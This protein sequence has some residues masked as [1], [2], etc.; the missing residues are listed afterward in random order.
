MN[1]LC[2]DV[3]TYSVKAVLFNAE[4]KSL[5]VKKVHEISLRDVGE[6]LYPDGNLYEKQLAIVADLIGER[7]NGKVYF[8]LPNELITSRHLTLPVT[9]R[10]KVDLMI[11]FQLDENLPYSLDQAHFVAQQT[12]RGN[13]TNVLVNVTKKSDFNNYH[14]TL[15]ICEL[16]PTAVTSELSVVHS[17]AAEK[18]I[19]GPMAII[20][21]GHSTTKCYIIYNE[22]VVLNHINY[23]AGSLIDEAIASTYNIDA[24]EAVIYKHQNCFFLTQG[25]LEGVNEKQREFA[26]LMTKTIS[27][28]M[29]D[30]RR[31][32]IGF[33]VKNGLNINGVYLT[34]GTSRI[35]NIHDFMSEQLGLQVEPLATMEGIKDRE[36]LITNKEDS[37]FMT[38]LMAQATR[39]KL[40]PSNFLTG[41][42]SNGSSMGLPLH[43]MAFI[44]IRSAAL[45]LLL[46]LFVGIDSYFVAKQEKGLNK[47]IVTQ[48]KDPALGLDRKLR[49]TWTRKIP[50]LIKS[51]KTNKRVVTQEVKSM[52]SAMNIN[53]VT[54]L[55]RVNQ[56]LMGTQ[57]VELVVF[58]SD[59]TAIS[60]TLKSKNQT[61]HDSVRKK[62]NSSGLSD[63]KLSGSGLTTA[64][65]F[66]HS[67]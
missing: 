39:A 59:G 15:K 25:Q 53:A 36:D 10:K 2:I 52:M 56:V 34:G 49:K 16:E 67:E 62:L 42:Y 13:E 65:R 18:K 24:D 64:F 19:Q 8:Q 7:F 55:F 23:I 48:M 47:K 28:L 40:K 46:S 57:D 33:R 38:T 63:M 66:T 31:W 3:G 54:P 32:L 35:N 17:L 5:R 12:K 30:I 27:P 61:T 41:E 45:F 44:G 4:G 1:L 60:G 9:Q 29:L 21:I 6:E 37:F 26:E 43:S 58:K 50:K 22:Q 20:D 51:L 11:P 14:Q